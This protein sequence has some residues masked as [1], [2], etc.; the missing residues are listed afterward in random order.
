MGAY[1]IFSV[2]PYE[3]RLPEYASD[4]QYKHFKWPNAQTLPI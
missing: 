2:Q 4:P 1:E 3:M